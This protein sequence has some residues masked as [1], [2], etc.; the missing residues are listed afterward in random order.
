VGRFLGRVVRRRRRHG[1][2]H[3]L[4]VL[5]GVDGHHVVHRHRI[6]RATP[7]KRALNSMKSLPSFRP[8]VASKP[9]LSTISLFL[10]YSRG[11]CTERSTKTA[12]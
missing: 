4:P 1:E 7:P 6:S 5:A 8:L 12:R 11:T 2:G 9:T 10:T 3:A